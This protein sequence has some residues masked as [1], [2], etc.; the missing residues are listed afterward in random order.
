MAK[1][2]KILIDNICPLY[3]LECEKAVLGTL[4]S[5]VLSNGEIPE[6]LTEDCFYDEFNR[7][8]FRAI[9]SIISRGDHPEPIAIKGRLDKMGISFNVAEL[10]KRLDGMTLDFNQYVNRLF[11]LSVHRKFREIG[12]YLLKHSASEE[13]DIEQVQTK[14]VESLSGMFRQSSDNIYTLKDGLTEVHQQVNRN[15]SGQTSL[16]GTPT[17]FDQFDRRSG[18]LQKSDL[19][20]IA[21]EQSMGKTSLLMSILRFAALSGTK[22]IIYSMEMRKEQIASRLASIESGVP[23]NQIMYSQLTSSQ[24]ESFD[25]G[26]ARL[27]HLPIYF[28][29]NSTSNIDSIINSIRYMKRKYDID[30]AAVD[31]L[32]ILN[33]NMKGANKEQQMGDVARRLKNLAKE[34]DIWII[35]LSQLNRDKDNPVPSIARLRDSGQIAEAADVVMLIYR[36]EVKGKPY[37]GEFSNVETKGTAMIDVAKGRNIGIMKFICKFDAPTTHFYDLQDIPISANVE[38]DPF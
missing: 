33:V 2:E 8:I 14:A 30:G 18:G 10:L 1:T 25:K 21:A 36:P 17:G 20:I 6:N 3:D 12:L 22:S 4:T 26:L 24:L 28:D 34:L 16:T 32:Q 19:I 23:A 13:E 9:D 27:L 5:P 31:Y 7:N 11:D 37:P 38:P 35:A 15:L 29:D